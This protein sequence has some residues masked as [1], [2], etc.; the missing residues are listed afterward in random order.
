MGLYFTCATNLS[1][2]LFC[3]G[4]NS[5][6]QLGDGTTTTRSTPAHVSFSGTRVILFALG[7]VHA[8]AIASSGGVY[9]WGF[10]GEGRLGVGTFTASQIPVKVN[11]LPQNASCIAAGDA[12]TC[13]VLAESGGAMC[14]GRNSLGSLGDGTLTTRS[15]PVAVVGLATGVLQIAARGDSTCALLRGSR[16]VRCWG[17][18]DYGQ[19][20]DGTTTARTVPTPVTGLEYGVWRVS[21]GFIFGCAALISDGSTR[22][23][24]YN[25]Q[26]QL[27]DGTFSSRLVP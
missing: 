25:G 26:G 20:G 5:H 22:C 24:G 13:V 10:N 19:L 12:H 4:S 15:T 8:C 14:W 1:L 27:G 9:C 21:L 17:K 7:S 2:D 16:G 6:G 3:W 23:W 11:G 18:N